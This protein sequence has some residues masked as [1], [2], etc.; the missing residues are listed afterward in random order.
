MVTTNSQSGTNVHEIADRIYRINTPVVME[1]GLHLHRITFEAGGV[2]SEHL[3]EHRWNLFYVISGSMLIRTWDAE[4][5]IF[6]WVLRAH[7]CFV[8]PCGVKHQFEGLHSGV[9]L[10][11]YWHDSNGDE[12][13]AH[14][15][16]RFTQGFMR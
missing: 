7:D 14:D 16:V 8:V 11:V 15:I 10:E 12:V 2:C 4:F 1:D 13:N 6:E 5:G 3:H 9:A